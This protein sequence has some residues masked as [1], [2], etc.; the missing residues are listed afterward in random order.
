MRGILQASA[1]AYK[2]MAR[3]AR[4]EPEAMVNVQGVSVQELGYEGDVCK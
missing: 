1:W 2:T 4:K 3:Q